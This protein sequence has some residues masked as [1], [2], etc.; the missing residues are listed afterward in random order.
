M[1]ITILDAESNTVTIIPSCFSQ[2]DAI[3]AAK[4]QVR[5]AALDGVT[6]TAVDADGVDV[7]ASSFPAVTSNPDVK[8]VGYERDRLGDNLATFS[9]VFG[10]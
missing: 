2:T 9:G 7:L 10:F 6:L 1:N 4:S 8:F 3:A 5:D